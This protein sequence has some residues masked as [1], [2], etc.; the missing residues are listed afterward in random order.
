MLWICP[1]RTFNINTG[2]S[3]AFMRISN[4]AYISSG[5]RYVVKP[6]LKAQSSKL[7]AQ[8]SKLKEKSNRLLYK[9]S[10]KILK[11]FTLL[12]LIITVSLLSLVTAIAVPSFTTM[13]QNNRIRS[14]TNHIISSLQ[15]A[16]QTAVIEQTEVTACTPELG[17]PQSCALNNQWKNGVAL[18]KGKA[19]VDAY[20]PPPPP[21]PPKQSAA[22]AEPRHPGYPDEPKHQGYP[23]EP[24]H[25]GYP[26]LKYP[27]EPR[28]PSRAF[29]KH[30][31]ALELVPVP[32]VPPEPTPVGG[33]RHL[34]VYLTILLLNISPVIMIKELQ[35][36]FI[37][38]TV[39]TYR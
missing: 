29:P 18:L 35:M 8:S 12:E 25:P 17:N 9:P 22:P 36:E 38:P 24:K 26:A 2:I 33:G 5:G 30:P 37:E 34:A 15:F 20:T 23:N 10:S 3:F 31:P 32:S 21:A 27:P 16:R 28:L 1:Q 11:G 13:V 14:T 7:K 4:T 39:S 6:K 19:K